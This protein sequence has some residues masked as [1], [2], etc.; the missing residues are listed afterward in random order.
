MSFSILRDRQLLSLRT[1]PLE[2]AEQDSTGYEKKVLTSLGVKTPACPSRQELATLFAVEK[3]VRK[4]SAWFDA[5]TRLKPH[6][7]SNRER[8]ESVNN[9]KSGADK[10]IRA[11]SS[12][13]K[14]QDA[15]S[16]LEVKPYRAIKRFQ[17]IKPQSL[18]ANV[19]RI[20]KTIFGKD[21][22]D[23][24]LSMDPMQ[25]INFT[26]FLQHYRENFITKRATKPKSS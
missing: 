2:I 1:A 9:F 23:D 18:E 22:L 20:I 7:E 6:L 21:K 5:S 25:N 13:E 24:F 14:F 8:L 11:F 3:H 10:E 26:G 4:F 17:D 12:L 19:L 16:K 15:L